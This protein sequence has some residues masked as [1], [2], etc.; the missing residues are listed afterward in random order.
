MP[1]QRH[2]KK[3][4]TA[5]KQRQWSHVRD[6]ELKKGASKGKADKIANGV[7]KKE[8]GRVKKK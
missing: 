7:I 3:A 2:T 5:K 4:D 6:S 8:S 1:A